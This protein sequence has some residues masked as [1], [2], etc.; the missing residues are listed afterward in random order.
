ML[1]PVRAPFPSVRFSLWGLGEERRASGAVIW[2]DS[3]L[4]SAR[5]DRVSC[6]SEVVGQTSSSILT[7]NIQSGENCKKEKIINPAQSQSAETDSSMK[8]SRSFQSLFWPKKPRDSGR[9][10]TCNLCKPC[11]HR[12]P[13]AACLQGAGRPP[14]VW[15]LYGLFC[16][17]EDEIPSREVDCCTGFIQSLENCPPPHPPPHPT[18]SGGERSSVASFASFTLWTLTYFLILPSLLVRYPV[19]LGVCWL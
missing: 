7:C 4:R 11:P 9:L 8:P 17:S 18:P 16:S 3:V 19:S 12:Q 13:C 2:A 6:H 5:T 10:V 1:V 15:M 14:A